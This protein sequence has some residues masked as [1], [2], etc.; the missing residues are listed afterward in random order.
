MRVLILGANADIALATAHCFAQQEGADICLASRNT[1]ALHNRAHDLET[2]YQVRAEV[3]AFDAQDCASHAAFY[4]SLAPKPDVV[5]LAFGVLPDQSA[6][7]RD[8][9]LAQESRDVNFTGAASILEIIAADFETK[10]RGQII[11]IGSPAGL[12]GRK[13]NYFYGAAKGALM[14]YLSGLRHRL[15]QSGVRV[16]T[17]IPG[18][19]DTKMIQGMDLPKKLTASP[20][21]AATAIHKAWKT[22][23]DQIYVKG[24]W[25]WIMLLIRLLPEWLFKRTNL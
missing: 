20:D 8:F 4:E 3:R 22:G 6:A 9:A 2:R 25:R 10:G 7:Q 18:F 17:V 5:L 14:V 12:R 21:Q 13:S 19:V 23:K 16:L 24:V 11:A 15:H 1:G